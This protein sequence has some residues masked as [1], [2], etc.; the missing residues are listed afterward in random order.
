MNPCLARA[1]AVAVP[2]NRVP[3]LPAGVSAATDTMPAVDL[4]AGTRQ[5]ELENVEAISAPPPAD[6]AE[7]SNLDEASYRFESA[8]AGVQEGEAR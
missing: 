4:V 7:A 2:S 6:L 5:L 3:L 8:F 1:T